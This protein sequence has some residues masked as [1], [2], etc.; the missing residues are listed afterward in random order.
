MKTKKIWRSLLVFALTCMMVCATAIPAF[1][2]GEIQTM[3]YYVL[4]V[5]DSYN[6]GYHY[7]EYAKWTADYECQYDYCGNESYNHSIKVADIKAQLGKANSYLSADDGWE[8]VGW[9]KEASANP[10]VI[11]FKPYYSNYPRPETTAT[12]TTYQIYLVAKKPTSDVVLDA[13]DGAYNDGS[14]RKTLTGKAGNDVTTANGYEEPTRDG[15]TFLGWA[16][17]ASASTVLDSIKFGKKS[18]TYYAVWEENIVEETTFD[19]IYHSVDNPAGR[20]VTEN[21]LDVSGTYNALNKLDGGYLYGGTFSDADCTSA[22]DF[23]N[24]ENGMGFTPKA[25]ETYHVWELE[26][27][28]LAPRNYLI[29]R[30][31]KPGSSVVHV[32]E[33]YMLFALDRLNYR[34]AGFDVDVE[35][36][37]GGGSLLSLDTNRKSIYQGDANETKIAFETIDVIRPDQTLEDYIYVRDGVIKNTGSG[38]VVNEPDRDPGY[39]VLSKLNAADFKAFSAKAGNSV[40]YVPYYVT[41]DGIR[42]TGNTMRTCGYRGE[43]IGAEYKSIDWKDKPV[44]STATPIATS[45]LNLFSSRNGI[46]SSAGSFSVENGGVEEN[47]PQK[48]VFGKK[49]NRR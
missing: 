7:S 46:M 44:D 34:E 32:S 8:I 23:A 49:M 40:S 37:S 16:A 35:E 45:R 5:D 27:K 33:L 36:S 42:V 28:Y 38:Y 20:K 4:Y 11:E 41:V 10:N 30:I 6:L 3:T 12:Q 9:S 18:A 25:G 29:W 19:V 47:V 1:A 13:N 17:T 2:K 39:I 48:P 31:V 14:T 15:Y 21:I 26:T 43:D 24:G 22:Y